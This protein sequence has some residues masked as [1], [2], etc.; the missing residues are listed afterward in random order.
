[1]IKT[2]WK[3][4]ES[5]GL[6]MAFCKRQRSSQQWIW[7]WLLCNRK[8]GT[9]RRSFRLSVKVQRQNFWV[10]NWEPQIWYTHSKKLFG[11]LPII[12]ISYQSQVFTK[13]RRLLVHSS[14]WP[15][16]SWITGRPYQQISFKRKWHFKKTAL[17]NSLRPKDILRQTN[18]SWKPLDLGDAWGT[19]D[20]MPGWVKD[21]AWNPY[22][23]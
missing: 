1:M 18:T 22:F 7:S 3:K 11:G 13:S 8:S 4:F 9:L 5:Y 15:T 17:F 20:T 14:G 16:R 2:A 12:E 19:M 23:F 6:W 10:G 21:A